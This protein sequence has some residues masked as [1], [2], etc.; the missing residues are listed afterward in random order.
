MSLIACFPAHTPPVATVMARKVWVSFK[1]MLRNEHWPIA[2]KWAGVNQ[3]DKLAAP[4]L[5]GVLSSFCDIDRMRPAMSA[6]GTKRTSPSHSAMCAFEGKADIERRGGCYPSCGKRCF[7]VGDRDD[8]LFTT[9]RF[10]Q[11]NLSSPFARAAA[12]P[13]AATVTAV[14]VKQLR[15]RFTGR[16]LCAAAD[17]AHLF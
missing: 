7:S 5:Q 4:Q 6:F 8:C 16:V 17:P 12:G 1:S 9:V 11:P 2:A 10:A 14:F 13:T 15:R 3:A